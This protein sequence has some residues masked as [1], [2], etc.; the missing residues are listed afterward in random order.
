MS[1]K[2]TFEFDPEKAGANRF[3]GKVTRFEKITVAE[4][5]ELRNAT[6]SASLGPEMKV[7]YLEVKNLTS[8][9]GLA[10]STFFSPGTSPLS[11]WSDFIQ[12]NNKLGIRIKGEKDPA[13]VGKI[14][15]WEEGKRKRGKY[16]DTGY[17]EPIN[18]PSPDELAAVLE[19]SG[20]APATAKAPSEVDDTYLTNLIL[21]TADGMTPDALKAELAGMGIAVDDA[22]LTK[23]IAQIIGSG[24]MKRK[25]GKY[26][27]V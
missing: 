15:E 22:R 7:M 16:G 4:F 27:V 8:A 5:D 26:E 24:S 23:L 13:Y 17:L 6:L 20:G 11:K 2:D 14:L 19:K 12:A 18:I 21:S 25:G 10:R 9:D 3:L 1:E